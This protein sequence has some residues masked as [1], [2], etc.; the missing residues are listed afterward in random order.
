MIMVKAGS[1]L[2][3][4]RS[5]KRLGK[6]NSLA[7]KEDQGSREILGLI[8]QFIITNRLDEPSRFGNYWQKGSEVS[9]F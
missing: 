4:K 2:A 1:F 7:S 5:W 6:I 8:E 3:P 9:C